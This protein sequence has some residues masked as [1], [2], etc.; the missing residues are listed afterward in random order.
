M[1]RMHS[2][3][4]SLGQLEAAHTRSSVRAARSLCSLRSEIAL[5][6]AERQSAVVGS[7]ARTDD[8]IP[9][10]RLHATATETTWLEC[11]MTSRLSEALGLEVFLALRVEEEVGIAI[12]LGFGSRGGAGRRLR[13]GCLFGGGHRGDN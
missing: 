13:C 5:S 7:A 12:R 9:I 8:P 4:T 6:F 11:F 10:A 3:R 2:F 1:R